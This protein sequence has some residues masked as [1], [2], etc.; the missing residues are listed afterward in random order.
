[1]V[2]YRVVQAITIDMLQVVVNSLIGEGWYPIGGVAV[3][4]SSSSIGQHSVGY[5]QA[6]ILE[7]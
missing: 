4:D 5:Y 1:M 2:K 6:M 3:I 7:K